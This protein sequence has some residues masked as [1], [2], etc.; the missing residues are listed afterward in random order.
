MNLFITGKF[1]L[2]VENYF[3]PVLPG[4]P[5]SEYIAGYPV[6]N[7][8]KLEV[9]KK[10]TLELK[11][12]HENFRKSAVDLPGTFSHGDA[13]IE[14][15]LVKETSGETYWVDFDTE[16]CDLE[17]KIER[18]ADDLRAL[19]YSSASISPKDIYEDA[20]KEILAVYNKP[21]LIDELKKWISDNRLRG[22]MLHYA[23]STIEA[24]RHE[25]VEDILINNGLASESP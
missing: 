5:V 15:V 20:I 12:L 22:D 13:S 1:Y 19:L 21:E 14:N 25:Y 23:Q 11:R 3:V 9:L 10:V 8:Q 4:V 16:H 7:E 6:T 2:M 24:D 18:Q 17:M